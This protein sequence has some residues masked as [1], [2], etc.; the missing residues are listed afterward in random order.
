MPRSAGEVRPHDGPSP[1]VVRPPLG[2]VLRYRVL[3]RRPAA[4]YDD[5]LR[6]DLDDRWYPLR[7]VPGTLAAVALAYGC[8]AVGAAL[9]R[10]S[11]LDPVLA[12]ALA[13]VIT[14]SDVARAASRRDATRDRLFGAVGKIGH[15]QPYR[16]LEDDE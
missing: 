15:F 9:G 13:V 2:V 6:A 10:W 11:P 4:R 1:T 16:H 3:G 5:W 7:G 12:V 14:V 8:W